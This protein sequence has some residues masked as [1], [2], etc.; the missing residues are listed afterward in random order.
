MTEKKTVIE[1]NWELNS[2]LFLQLI[3]STHFDSRQYRE[4]ITIHTHKIGDFF[5]LSHFWT[6]FSFSIF[7]RK[8]QR[9]VV[10]YLHSQGEKLN[11]KKKKS[12]LD[13]SRRRRLNNWKHVQHCMEKSELCSAG[14]KHSQLRAE[15]MNIGFG[16]KTAE[17]AL[18]YSHIP[19]LGR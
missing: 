17:M 12:T 1:S 19:A 2:K 7:R 13:L 10:C 8:C 6:V 3:F 11:R 16:S 14:W 9:I 18:F 15:A 5:Y 4:F